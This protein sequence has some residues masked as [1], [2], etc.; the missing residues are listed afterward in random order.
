MIQTPSILEDLVRRLPLPLA[1]LYRR[2]HNAKTP[3]ERHLTALSL[4]EASLKLL[5]STCIVEY[6]RLCQPTPKVVERL[7]NLARPTLGHWWEFARLLLTELAQTNDDGFRAASEFLLGRARDDLP[8]TAGLDATLTEVLQ[9]R[10]SA[11][12]T[13]RVSELYD[14]LVQYRNKGVGHAAPAGREAEFHERMARALL[15]GLAELF[16]RFDV[17]A[18]RRLVFVDDVR[19]QTNGNWLVERYELTGESRARIASLEMAESQAAVLPHTQRIYVEQEGSPEAARSA[20]HPLLDYDPQTQQVWFLNSRRAQLRTEY[21]CYTSGDVREQRDQSREQRSLLAHVLGMTVDE[22]QF[23]GFAA[24]SKAEQEAAE[25]IAGETQPVSMQS[26]P[27]GVRHIGEFELLS[28]LGRG[29]MGD[30]YRAWQPSLGR[31]VALKCVRHAGDAKAEARFAREIR[32]LGRVDHPNLVK[33]FTS[34]AEGDQWFYAMELVEGANLGDICA[35]LQAS[36]SSASEV[37]LQAFQSTL[38]QVQEQTRAAEKPLSESQ[39]ADPHPRAAGSGERAATYLAAAGAHDYVHHVVELM[40]QVSRAAHALHEA[41]VIHRDIKPA[42]IMVTPDGKQAVLLDLGLAQLADH[43][44]GRLTRTRQFV[45]TLRYASPEQVLAVGELDRRSD[46]YSLGATLWELLALRPIFG[47]DDQ[48]PTPTLMRRIEFEE[49]TRL[50]KCHPGLARDLEAIVDRCLEKRAEKRYATCAELA[51]ELERFLRDEPVRARNIKGWERSWRWMRRRPALAALLVTSVLIV[52]AIVGLGVGSFYT[53]R[54]QESNSK[55]EATLHQLETS[56]SQVAKALQAAE[57]A[58]D[59]EED[60]RIKAEADRKLAAERAVQLD[61]LSGVQLMVD[62]DWPG[63]LA[64]FAD[65]AEMEE[66]DSDRALVH[67]QRLATCLAQCARLKQVWFHAAPVTQASFSPDGQR[68]VT[69]AQDGSAR[70]WNASDGQP[71]GD[72]LA[73]RGVAVLQAAFSPDG[74]LLSTASS[75]GA[76]DLWDLGVSPPTRRDLSPA[77]A[78]PVSYLAF[79]PDGSLLVACDKAGIARLLDVQ[80]QADSWPGLQHAAAVHYA[81]FSRDGKQLVTSSEDGHAYVWNLDRSARRELAEIPLEP[82]RKPDDPESEQRLP[83]QQLLTERLAHPLPVVQA[84]FGLDGK[85]IVAFVKQGSSSTANGE[86]AFQWKFGPAFV[87]RGPELVHLDQVN[88]SRFSPRADRFATASADGLVRVWDPQ[89]NEPSAIE[90]PHGSGVLDLSWSSDGQ[91]L[92]TG[93]ADKIA[94]IWILEPEPKVVLEI[95]HDAEVPCVA[96]LPDGLSLV[97]GDG[98]GR[99]TIRDATTGAVQGE[100]LTTPEYAAVRMAVSS[101][102]QRLACCFVDQSVRVWNLA[103]RAPLGEPIWHSAEVRDVRFNHDGTQVATACYDDVARVYEVGSGAI[104]W[105][106][107]HVIDVNTVAFARPEDQALVTGADDGLRWWSLKTGE[108]VGA[109]FGGSTM[110]RSLDVSRAAGSALLGVGYY[111]GAAQFWERRENSWSVN[112]NISFQGLLRGGGLSPDGALLGAVG[113]DNTAIVWSGSTLDQIATFYQHAGLV[114]SVAF[115]PTSTLAVSAGQDHTVRMWDP[116]TGDQLRAPLRHL[117]RVHSA[118]F[119]PDGRYVLSASADGT[120]RLWD[121]MSDLELETDVLGAARDDMLYLSHDGA[122]VAVLENSGTVSIHDALNGRATVSPFHPLP[123]TVSLSWSRDGVHLVSTSNSGEVQVW[124]TAGQSARKEYEF[125]HGTENCRA[126]LSPDARWLLSASLSSLVLRETARDAVVKERNLEILDTDLSAEALQSYFANPNEELLDSHGSALGIAFSQNGRRVALSLSGSV[127]IWALEP[128]LETPPETVLPGTAGAHGLAFSPDGTLLAASSED[129]TV[130][131]WDAATGEPRS[132]AL[133]HNGRVRDVEFSPDG[134]RL[135]TSCD[136]QTAQVW[137]IATGRVLFALRH[138]SAVQAASYAAEGRLI[139]SRTERTVQIWDAER[140]EPLSFPFSFGAVLTDAVLAPAGDQ[141]LAL[142]SGHRLSRWQLRVARKTSVPDTQL[143]TMTAMARAYAGRR[144]DGAVLRPLDA[145]SFGRGW[146]SLRESSAEAPDMVAWHAAMAIRQANA[147]ATEKQLR[148]SLWHLARLLHFERAA[149][150]RAR[151]LALQSEVHAQLNEWDLAD[152]DLKTAATLDETRP[153]LGDDV[154]RLRLRHA[155]SL[156]ELDSTKCAQ[157]LAECRATCEGLDKQDPRAI[158]LRIAVADACMRLGDGLS[159]P[160]PDQAEALFADCLTLLEPVRVDWPGSVALR[161]SLCVSLRSRGDARRDASQWPEARVQYERCLAQREFLEQARSGTRVPTSA[162]V[163]LC[164]ELGNV[165]RK[166]PDREAAERSFQRGLAEIEEMSALNLLTESDRQN[167]RGLSQRLAE[168]ALEAGNP[169][170]ATRIHE[171]VVSAMEAWYGMDRNNAAALEQL[172]LSRQDLGYLH[173]RLGRKEQARDLYERSVQLHEDLL[174]GGI[175]GVD[176]DRL[177]TEQLDCADRMFG[178]D[179]PT[180]A[181]AHCRRALALRREL[182]A[183]NPE[184]TEAKEQVAKVLE[185]LGDA[186][187]RDG[188]ARQAIQDCAESVRL[189]RE[190]V[191]TQLND[192]TSQGNLSAGL[193]WLGIVSAKAGATEEARSAMQERVAL[194]LAQRDANPDDTSTIISLEI[195]LDDLGSYCLEDGQ[196]PA[197]LETFQ[198]SIAL[199]RRRIELAP[200]DQDLPGQLAAEYRQLGNAHLLPGDWDRASE[201]FSEALM[202]VRELAAKADPLLVDPVLAV[203]TSLDD[204]RIVG[205]RSG[206]Y[207]AA[208]QHATEC[209]EQLE[210]L[211]AQ[212]L[213]IQPSHRER[214][215]AARRWRQICDLDLAAITTLE[216]VAARPADLRDELLRWY[217]TREVRAGRYREAVAA[218]EQAAVLVTDEGEQRLERARDLATCIHALRR[219]RAAAELDGIEQTAH[220]EFQQLLATSLEQALEKGRHLREIVNDQRLAIVRGEPA[221][222]QLI[223]KYDVAAPTASP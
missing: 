79:S 203:C 73:R 41:D 179:F 101:D 87:A 50:R 83:P 201:A 141:L 216:S 126:W 183:E 189:R 74:G 114:N 199:T 29:G 90:L 22:A 212:G 42:N 16:T 25:Q 1:Q 111:R 177:A 208:R 71:V 153:D 197:A 206:Q 215:M 190:V 70:I 172:K 129:Q 131:V 95:P 10:A 76:V 219:G 44:E 94:R 68:V 78:Q 6:A 108:L 213:L 107:Q 61:V 223:E 28:L 81:D 103:D 37:D 99:L 63:A 143:E 214:L 27:R 23:D 124:N 157:I 80:P 158:D 127:I 165:C 152:T 4:W 185:Y 15:S 104:V 59:R 191:V 167:Q 77:T 3:L 39:S 9:G 176:R 142:V 32:A 139:L 72:N 166:I 184:S 48:L 5:A 67:Q 52:L 96:F 187:I 98:N 85:T 140:G 47:A 205:L 193:K 119:S 148:A 181:V 202:I 19:R 222:R 17:L 137:E 163:E 174:W 105:A 40:R 26:L 144:V 125:K 180:Q 136:D 175:A 221:Y 43:V 8:R 33:V 121:L 84:L 210:R 53:A 30:V 195:A 200:N 62:M 38:S 173:Q 146:P 198:Q 132:E 89:Q 217:A 162:V 151:W 12:T 109:P 88:A 24:T 116:S 14:R 120:A 93:C 170:Q 155:E 86:S 117:G 97:T 112:A 211:E 171:Q 65:A 46:I 31:Q 82:A 138:R 58:Q 21:L 207:A 182:L 196:G 64:W 122:R 186:D 135:L 100:P 123:R 113:P 66:D 45:G 36:A 20:L 134:K 128:G 51:D 161:D 34:G 218:V 156:R 55:L 145:A 154:V 35:R 209:A 160:Q 178:L 159:T 18:R 118:S 130:R 204:L 110:V 194:R 13:V 147:E 164:L 220:D 192:S 75:N 56:R 69:V 7:R 2:A 92:L 60:L 57:A 11:R 54:L 169:Q 49:P 106:L 150:R 168:M 115:D 102:G 133:S 91:R 149:P 188:Q